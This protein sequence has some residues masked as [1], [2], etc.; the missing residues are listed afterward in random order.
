[1]KERKIIFYTL[2]ASAL[3]ILFFAGHT[4]ATLTHGENFVFEPLTKA[5]K[6]FLTAANSSVYQLSIVPVLE[7]KCYSCHNE[8]KAKGGLVMTSIASFKNGGKHGKE[9]VEGKPGESNLIKVI[10]LPLT[11]DQH[12]PPDGKAQLTAQEITLLKFWIQSGANFDLKMAELKPGDSLRLVASSMITALQSAEEKIYPFSPASESLVEK[13]NSPFRSLFPLFQNSP[14]LRADFFVQE[15]FQVKA[16]EELKEVQDQ[17]VELNLSHMPV[18]DKELSIVGKFKNL[19]KLN[20]NFTK[21]S[22]DLSP[23]QSLRHLKSLSL[24]GT[25]ITSAALSAVFSLPELRELFIWNTAVAEQDQAALN[26]QHKNISIVW[27]IFNDNSP[28]KLSPPSITNNSVLKR[29]ERLVLKH[30]MP[31]VTIRYTVDG[32]KPDSLQGQIY[33]A[34]IPLGTT[35]HLKARAYK[36]GWLTSDVYETMCFLEGNK[37]DQIELFTKPDRQ[38]PGEGTQGLMD[39]KKGTA[40]L[41]KEP[42]WMGFKENAF[43]AGFEFGKESPPLKNIVISYGRNTGAFIFPPSEVE[44]WAG[45]NK[46]KVVL[47]KAIKIIQPTA[48][49]P[50]KVDALIIPLTNERKSYYKIIVKPVGKLPAWHSGKGQKGW[51]F[52]DEIFFN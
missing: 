38:Y 45:D 52:V 51:F 18:T 7:K 34:P 20:L 1:M 46:E 21:V 47:I 8:T 35:T 32:S 36:E 5:A 48:N 9:W 40:D 22:S 37:A 39:G 41:F 23:L 15:A 2:N 12:M 4:G 17:L 10:H 29:D 33:N 28:V 16:L 24:S 31:G 3:L 43:I 11:H 6:K 49:E 44:V 27:N 14:A 19:E 42:S 50:A 26:S 13:L 30:V 25:A